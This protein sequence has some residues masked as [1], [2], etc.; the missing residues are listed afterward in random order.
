MMILLP[1]T[2]MVKHSAASLMKRVIVRKSLPKS[3]NVGPHL[4]TG[5]AR[6][7]TD[8]TDYKIF[9]QLKQ[10]T[11]Q[12]VHFVI[13]KVDKPNRVIKKMKLC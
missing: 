12:N 3:Q 2:R 10:S 11:E 4:S 9:N 1:Y 8:A 5:N 6:V 7:N 13:C